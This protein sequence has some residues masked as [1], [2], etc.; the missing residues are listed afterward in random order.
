MSVF[1]NY[2]AFYLLFNTL[3]GN[4]N[5]AK[6]NWIEVFGELINEEPVTNGNSLEDFFKFITTDEWTAPV[7]YQQAQLRKNEDSQAIDNGKQ[8]HYGQQV[9]PKPEKNVNLF[10]NRVDWQNAYK[11]VVF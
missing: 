7:S 11:V 2:K 3:D 5:I 4:N 1:K 9:Q 10:V 8:A 6:M